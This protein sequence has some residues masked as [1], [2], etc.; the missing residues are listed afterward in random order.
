MRLFFQGGP[1]GPPGRTPSACVSSV[2]SANGALETRVKATPIQGIPPKKGTARRR[3]Q[4]SPCFKD[5]ARA[6]LPKQIDLLT[7][8]FLFFMF[9]PDPKRFVFTNKMA[10][11]WKPTAPIWASNTAPLDLT[12]LERGPPPSKRLHRRQP[13]PGSGGHPKGVQRSAV[14]HGFGGKIIVVK[15]K[16][17]FVWAISVE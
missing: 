14:S 9:S 3:S 1:L 17:P 7:F 2:H 8:G 4:D 10:L 6:H 16:H 15:T 12:A 13:S 5:L 11:G